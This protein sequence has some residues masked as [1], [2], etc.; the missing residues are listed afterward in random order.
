[1]YSGAHETATDA[2]GRC[3]S[4]P[5]YAA[6]EVPRLC[7]PAYATR[8]PRA[9]AGSASIVEMSAHEGSGSMITSDE[10]VSLSARRQTA[11]WTGTDAHRHLR[12]LSDCPTAPKKEMG[13]GFLARTHP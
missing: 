7:A 5:G 9:G 2:T 4:V 3:S 13:S 10:P 12:M 1:V 6:A 11:G 8:A